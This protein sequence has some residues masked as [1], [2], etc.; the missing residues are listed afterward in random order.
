MKID[1]ETNQETKIDQETIKKWK[2]SKVTWSYCKVT[3]SQRFNRDRH[4]KNIYQEDTLVF[5]HDVT[6]ADENT[7]NDLVDLSAEEPH[8]NVETTRCHAFPVNENDNASQNNNDEMLN[9]SFIIDTGKVRK[10]K[11]LL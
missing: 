8:R 1:Q 7:F 2:Q 6:E 11:N 3:F 9:A 4:V 5:A 10:S